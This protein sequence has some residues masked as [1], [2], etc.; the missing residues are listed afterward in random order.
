MTDQTHDQ[1]SPDSPASP[2]SPVHADRA[3]RADSAQADAVAAPAPSAALQGYPR[4]ASPQADADTVPVEVPG[5]QTDP[6]A[7]LDVFPEDGGTPEEGGDDDGAL[8]TT[9]SP[10]RS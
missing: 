3:D 9:P 8:K 2:D 1:S 4:E 10:W 6:S 7:R 5:E